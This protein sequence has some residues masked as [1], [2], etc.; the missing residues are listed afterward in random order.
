MEKIV[1][2]GRHGYELLAAEFTTI[3]MTQSV[4]VLA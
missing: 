2:I 1:K 4:Y 3:I